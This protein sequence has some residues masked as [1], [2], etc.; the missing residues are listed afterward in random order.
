MR[1]P[2]SRLRTSSLTASQTRSRS[3]GPGPS[4]RSRS[5]RH[6][7]ATMSMAT[8]ET[9]APIMTLRPR[10][11]ASTCS[12]SYCAPWSINR[13][14]GG[15]WKRSGSIAKGGVLGHCTTVCSVEFSAW[16]P[17]SWLRRSPLASSNSSRFWRP[18]FSDAFSMRWSTMFS[19]MGLSGLSAP[20]SRCD[21][22][23]TATVSYRTRC[24]TISPA[25]PITTCSR[26]NPSGNSMHL[27]VRR[28]FHTGTRR[29][30]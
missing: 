20:P 16:P 5:T 14:R 26:R 21:V 10:G 18:R 17:S 28:S 15:A 24:T 7:R 22:P 1:W 23:G 6:S 30:R 4:L 25:M 19:T 3:S 11:V 29:C 2:A 9:S 13:S 12:H 8:I 27:R